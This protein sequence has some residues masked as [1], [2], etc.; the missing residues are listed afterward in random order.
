MNVNKVFT[1]NDVIVRVFF[2]SVQDLFYF[3]F[4]PPFQGLFMTD[5]EMISLSSS[6]VNCLMLTSKQT[7]EKHIVNDCSILRAPTPSFWLYLEKHHKIHSH[8]WMY[9]TN[10]SRLHMKL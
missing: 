2:S 7:L 8:M 5:L 10:M 1:L 9:S 3:H 6:A 4:C